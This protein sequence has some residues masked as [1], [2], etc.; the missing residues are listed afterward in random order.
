VAAVSDRAPTADQLADEDR[1]RSAVTVQE[2]V[3]DDL[4]DPTTPSRLDEGRLVGF[5]AALRDWQDPEPG[6]G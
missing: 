6:G 5:D 1:A 3:D 4:A 2:L